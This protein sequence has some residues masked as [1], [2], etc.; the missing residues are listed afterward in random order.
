M[1]DVQLKSHC[2]IVPSYCSPA[3]TGD[4]KSL[5]LQWMHINS[6]PCGVFFRIGLFFSLFY[7]GVMLCEIKE[8]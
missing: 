2:P 7:G 5:S 6:E 3:I 4:F 1:N 8:A